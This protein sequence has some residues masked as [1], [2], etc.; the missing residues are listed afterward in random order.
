MLRLILILYLIIAVALRVVI[1]YRTSARCE[2]TNIHQLA[3]ARDLK[4]QSDRYD[5]ICV[6]LRGR[7]VASGSWLNLFLIQHYILETEGGERF[8]V[9]VENEAVPVRGTTQIICTGTFRQFYS[10]EFGQMTGIVE[11]S[12]MYLDDSTDPPRVQEANS[13]APLR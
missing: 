1:F 5:Q 10:T 12:K 3:Q 9:F 13:Q 8:Y 11:S 7:V 4:R 2:D 6:S